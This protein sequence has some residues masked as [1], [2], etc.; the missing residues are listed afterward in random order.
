MDFSI[1][2]VLIPSGALLGIL[3]IFIGITIT[4]CIVTKKRGLFCV[5][6]IANLLYAYICVQDYG[7]EIMLQCKILSE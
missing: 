4:T 5:I 7:Q 3:I 2:I 1:T 6:T